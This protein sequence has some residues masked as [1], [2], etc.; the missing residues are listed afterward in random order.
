MLDALFGRWI[1][2]RAEV[3]RHKGAIAAH[4][5][6]LQHAAAELEH[7]ERECRRLGIALVLSTPGAGAIHGHPSGSRSESR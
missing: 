2:L 3:K 4:R 6:Q 5:A 7:V 1:H